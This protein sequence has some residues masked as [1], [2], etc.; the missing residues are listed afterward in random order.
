M[1][2]PSLDMLLTDVILP[3]YS[4]KE[5]YSKL[6]ETLPHLKVLYMSGYTDNVISD[7]GVLK[8]GVHFIGKPFSI[9][10]LLKKVRLVLN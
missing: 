3:G 1:E 10:E 7:K 8:A 4:G 6:K 2:N 5:L 9:R